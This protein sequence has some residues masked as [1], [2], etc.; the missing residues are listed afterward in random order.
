MMEQYMITTVLKDGISVKGYIL[1]SNTGA[2]EVRNRQEV[3]EMALRGFIV[4]A[5][6][7]KQNNQITLSGRGCHLRDLPVKQLTKARS[8]TK[9]VVT[10][11]LV[12]GRDLVGYI[13]RNDMGE[14]Q[15]I[16]IETGLRMTR[17]KDITNAIVQKY[18]DGK[19]KLRG[20]NSNDSNW[21][22]YDIRN[23]EARRRA[24]VMQKQLE[25]TRQNYIT[26]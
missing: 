16:N 9:W 25:H 3:C 22:S 5:I 10:G 8:N 19:S 2:N 23:I 20:R 14:T 18:T 1:K 21:V 11:R 26:I 13:I 24:E 6:A 4:N 17:S 15:H 12:R 7:K